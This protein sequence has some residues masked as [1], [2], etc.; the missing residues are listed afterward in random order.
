LVSSGLTGTP[1]AGFILIHPGIEIK[2]IEGYPLLPHADLDHV[3]TDLGVEAVL[4]HPEI[5]GRVPQPYQSGN[6]SGSAVRVVLHLSAG[7]GR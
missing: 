5:E 2:S 7:S 6:D 1:V 3:G 4:V